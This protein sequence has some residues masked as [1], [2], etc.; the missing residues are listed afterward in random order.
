[1]LSRSFDDLYNVHLSCVLVR[2]LNDMQSL[3][4][5]ICTDEFF[6]Q[7]LLI[8][9]DIIVE[10]CIR[11]RQEGVMMVLTQTPVRLRTSKSRADHRRLRT[12][13][14]EHIEVF[15]FA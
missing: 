9:F 13:S 11:A 1:M 3:L 5:I 7:T 2:L 4:T 12:A 15:L 6:H 8:L 14:S 10:W